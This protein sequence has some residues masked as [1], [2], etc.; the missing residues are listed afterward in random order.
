[1]DSKTRNP[2]TV[3]KYESLVIII[4]H[5]WTVLVQRGRVAMQGTGSYM[6]LKV[7]IVVSLEVLELL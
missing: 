2:G 6:R 3:G 1:L 5:N 7:P 4:Y